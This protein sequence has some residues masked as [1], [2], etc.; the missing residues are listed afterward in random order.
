MIRHLWGNLKRT[1]LCRIRV[2]NIP[3]FNEK[4]EGYKIYTG[5]CCC[6]DVQENRSNFRD[7]NIVDSGL[8]A[9]NLSRI[10]V[11]DK[12][13]LPKCPFSRPINDKGNIAMN[14]MIV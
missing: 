4:A 9:F 1:L 5:E 10:C 8:L 12:L 3:R 2:I 13:L 14:H 11:E 6:P 7:D